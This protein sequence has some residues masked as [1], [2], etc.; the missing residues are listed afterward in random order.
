MSPFPSTLRAKR[1]TVAEMARKVLSLETLVNDL[2]HMALDL[3]QQISA[4]EER[5]RCTD[6]ADVVN[7]PLAQAMTAR[8]AKL[9]HSV[10]DLRSRLT[11]G[12]REL[13]QAEAELRALESPGAHDAR[14]LPNQGII[15]N[16]HPS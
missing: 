12:R 16:A 11:V 1:F 3:D 5:T 13:E 6:P 4:E 14:E 8:R 9:L 2:Q 15:T 10:A 7:S